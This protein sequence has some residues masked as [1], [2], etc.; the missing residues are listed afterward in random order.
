MNKIKLVLITF[1]MLLVS[2]C[3]VTSSVNMPSTYEKGGQKVTASKTHANFLALAPS[4]NNE[5]LI[6]EL[7]AKCPTGKVKNVTTSFSVRGLVIVAL[8][9]ITATGECNE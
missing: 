7:A 6:E 8:E 2:N 3:A 5:S 4:S 9:T 1:V